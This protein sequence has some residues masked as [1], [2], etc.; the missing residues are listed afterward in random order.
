MLGTHFFKENN[1]PK[2]ALQIFNDHG[3]NFVRLRLWHT[4]TNGYN[5]L[6]KTLVMANRAKSLGLKI[7]LDIHYTTK[8]VRCKV[9]KKK[10]Y[11]KGWGNIAATKKFKKVKNNFKNIKKTLALIKLKYIL[12]K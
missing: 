7:L 4:P 1:I 9:K 3:I 2:D 5:N 10:I 11:S 12:R 8:Y 6:E